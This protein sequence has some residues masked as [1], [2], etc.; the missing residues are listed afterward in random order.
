[1]SLAIHDALIMIDSKGLIRYWN[2]AAET[3]FE[4]SSE[5]A[6]GREM[7]S[8]FVPEAN[9]SQAMAGLAAFSRRTGADSRCREGSPASRWIRI[10]GR[11]WRIGLSG[12]KR[13]GMR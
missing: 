5:E 2:H 11:S 9:R 6:M 13:M 1:M 10:S 12:Q 3:L 8:L 7:H 4:I